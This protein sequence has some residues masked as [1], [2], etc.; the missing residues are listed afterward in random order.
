MYAYRN[1]EARSFNQCN[2]GKAIRITY[3]ECV[4]VALNIQHALSMGH[5]ICGLSGCITFFHIISRTA[6]ILKRYKGTE[7]KLCVLIFFYNFFRNNLFILRT[8]Y[9]RFYD[10]YTGSSCKVLVSLLYP[11]WTR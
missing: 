6:T 11:L 7:H 3:S 10:I 4:S 2:I 1:I 9:A 8:I 5:V